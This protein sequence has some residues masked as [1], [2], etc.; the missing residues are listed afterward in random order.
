[1]NRHANSASWKVLLLMYKIW[2]TPSRVIEI[3]AISF[4]QGNLQT[5]D[6]RLDF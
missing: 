1:M 6:L 5:S 2:Q 4:F 3:K